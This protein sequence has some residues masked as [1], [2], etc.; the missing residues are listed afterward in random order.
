MK[1]SGIGRLLVT[2]QEA[3]ELKSSKSSGE[4]YSEHKNTVVLYHLLSVKCYL[5]YSIIRKVQSVL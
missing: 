3:T 1:A 4:I 5:P 2:V